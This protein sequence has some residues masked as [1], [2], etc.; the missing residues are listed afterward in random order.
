M[1]PF[2]TNYQIV[3]KWVYTDMKKGLG[4]YLF[5]IL[6][7][8]PS[9]QSLIYEEPTQCFTDEQIKQ[10]RYKLNEMIRTFA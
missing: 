5:G 9:V 8:G 1:N 10:V 3:E 6:A 7:Q 2:F 4:Y